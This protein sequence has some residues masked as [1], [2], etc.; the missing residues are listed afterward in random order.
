MKDEPGAIDG[1]LIDARHE[2][3][4]R[5]WG[6]QGQL[7]YNHSLLCQLNLPYRNPGD[8]VRR[9][10]RKSGR[11]S[12]QVE[13]GYIFNGDEFVPVGLPW[14]SRSRL[15]MLHL[16]SEA[17]KNNSAIVEVESSF[18]AFAKT[19]GLS[20]NGANL[21]SL[22]DQVQR[23]SAVQLRIAWDHGTHAD[24]G[25]VRPVF[26]KLRA[27]FPKHPRQ[28][29]LWTSFVEFHHDFY[30]SLR[31][32]AVPLQLT[33]IMG[34]RNSARSLDLYT[35][36][37]SRLVR[38]KRPTRVSWY[39]L[40][41]QFGAPGMDRKSFKR[42]IKSSLKKVLYVYPEAKVD[43]VTGGVLLHRSPPPVRKRRVG[44]IISSS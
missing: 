27:E 39:Q 20:V 21:R 23:M 37:A 38:V 8:G 31:E 40:Q 29:V 35:W 33:A 30:Q 5:I 22:R 4:N 36:L 2:L 26:S 44:E 10:Q 41:D 28:R 15:L 43:A 32:H 12:L 6:E 17:V 14:G 34:L 19:L 11:V 25:G 16:C 18:T 7:L 9:Y 24:Q 42:N 13:A 3:V 1:R